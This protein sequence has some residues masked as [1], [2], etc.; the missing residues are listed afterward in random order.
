MD[1]SKVEAGVLFL[2]CRDRTKYGNHYRGIYKQS[3]RLK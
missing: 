2:D 1:I 3:S